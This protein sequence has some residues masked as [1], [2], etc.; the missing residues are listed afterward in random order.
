M[1]C[2]YYPVEPWFR[3]RASDPNFWV[4]RLHY[5]A[6]KIYS[7]FFFFHIGKTKGSLCKLW[8]CRKVRENLKWL[9]MS[10]LKAGLYN[11]ILE[12]VKQ[13]EP[14]DIWYFLFTIHLYSLWNFPLHIFE[15]LPVSKKRERHDLLFSVYYFLMS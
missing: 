4:Y 5:F 1:S 13:E 15:R 6:L 11:T 2:S 3:S 12:L 14:H 10:S 8:G 9:W 7:C